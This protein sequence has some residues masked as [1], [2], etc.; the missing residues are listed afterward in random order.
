MN[1]NIGNCNTPLSMMYKFTGPKISKD[2]EDMVN[3][4]KWK[5]EATSG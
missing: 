4:N 2:T 3:K 1:S 5:S